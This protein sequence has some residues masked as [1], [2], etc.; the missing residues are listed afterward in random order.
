MKG[1][2]KEKDITGRLDELNKTRDQASDYLAM[3]GG[4][5]A[6][7]RKYFR[8]AKTEANSQKVLDDL[9]QQLREEREANAKLAEAL[10]L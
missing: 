6:E 3:Y 2:R 10:N 1:Y 4:N 8:V 9:Q 5:E 7:V